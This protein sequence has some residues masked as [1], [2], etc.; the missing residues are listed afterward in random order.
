MKKTMACKSPLSLP[1]CVFNT[2]A[3]ETAGIDNRAADAPA[4]ASVMELVENIGDRSIV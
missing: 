3:A 4:R 2:G 1:V